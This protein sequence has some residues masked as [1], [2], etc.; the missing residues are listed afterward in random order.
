[1]A[2]T[3][4]NTLRG[5]YLKYQWKK[6]AQLLEPFRN[7]HQGQ[8]CFIIGNGPSLNKMDLTKLNAYHSFGMNKIFLIFDRQ[9][10]Q[11]SYHVAINALVIKQS[12]DVL[13]SLNCPSFI[14]LDGILK[15]NIR[16]KNVYPL[17][18][19]P[20]ET[21]FFK[22]ITQGIKPGYTVTYVAMQLA[23]FMGFK[24]VFLVGVDH[25]FA[26]KGKAN[27][28][29]IMQGDDQN[30]FD[31]NY[32]KGQAWHLADLENSEVYYTIAKYFYESDGRKI[33]DATV[34]GKLDI[35]EKVTFEEA[36][37]MAS[38]K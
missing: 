38:K 18:D 17:G 22:D 37:Q 26:Q 1:M 29:Q 6:Q 36:L 25:S 11:L 33:Y 10:L 27:E 19:F 20:Q 32:F 15:N 24:R 28:K 16:A 5:K 8:D 12:K 23:Y 4:F 35:F 21:L 3:A 7:I 2:F 30:H 14:S 13:S 9:P 34:D 31:P